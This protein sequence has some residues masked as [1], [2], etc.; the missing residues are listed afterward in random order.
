MVAVSAR[1]DRAFTGN[2]PEATVSVLALGPGA[3]PG[4]SARLIPVARAPEGIA[5]TPDGRQVWVGSNQDSTVL[6]VDVARGVATDT[7]RG[8]GMPYRIAVTP[9]ARTVVITD[10]VRAEVRVV[11]AATRRVRHTIAV[12]ADSLVATAEVPGS[13]SPEGVALSRDGRWAF[14][15]LQGR[16]R[17]ATI[18]LRRGVIVRYAPT[19]TWSDGVAWSPVRVV[20]ATRK[21]G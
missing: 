15:T 17:V 4:D 21:G 13:P 20:G 5:V 8:F 16:N 1:G 14:V 9:D 7:L 3:A 12:P 2:I 10:P 19:G 6:V 11:D 18:D